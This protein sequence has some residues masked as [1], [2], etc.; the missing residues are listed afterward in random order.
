ML[1]KYLLVKAVLSLSTSAL[2]GP[3]LPPTQEVLR[4]P[5]EKL[6]LGT[7][8]MRSTITAPTLQNQVKDAHKR[9]RDSVFFDGV[10]SVYNVNFFSNDRFLPTRIGDV[11]VQS[12]GAW[13]SISLTKSL[14]EPPLGIFGTQVIYDS[15]NNTPNLYQFTTVDWTNW[16]FKIRVTHFAWESVSFLDWYDLYQD[17]NRETFGRSS[18]PAPG[19]VIALGIGA[20]YA[21]AKRSRRIR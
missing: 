2:G 17:L 3:I 19:A 11:W 1:C 10:D 5:Y 13:N 14:P 21:A 9:Y 18:I 6:D 15:L 12:S 20:W 16:P 8:G 4:W 7:L